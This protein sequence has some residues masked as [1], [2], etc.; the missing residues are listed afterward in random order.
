MALW[1]QIQPVSV[2]MWVPP[3]ALLSWLRI[4]VA[5]SC[6]VGHG[7]AWAPALLRL[8]RRPAAVASILTPTL[9]ISICCECSPKKAKKSKKLVILYSHGIKIIS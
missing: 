2:K 3:L 4:H 7:P 1:K 6:S 9:G 8:W 5:V